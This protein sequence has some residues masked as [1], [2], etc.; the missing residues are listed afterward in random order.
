MTSNDIPLPS[1]VCIKISTVFFVFVSVF[2]IFLGTQFV[3]LA[4]PF[5]QVEGEYPFV[6]DNN[7]ESSFRMESLG[8]RYFSV[9]SGS[10]TL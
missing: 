4:D 6:P 1:E 8:E 9:A 3:I 10:D 7:D 2:C 5:F